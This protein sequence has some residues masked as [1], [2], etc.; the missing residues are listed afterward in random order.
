MTEGLLLAF[1]RGVQ[2]VESAAQDRDTQAF[3]FYLLSFEQVCNAAAEGCSATQRFGPYIESGWVRLELRDAE[4][5]KNSPDDCRQCHQRGLDRPALLMREL[6]GPW[7][8]FFSR[9]DEPAFPYPEP[10]GG[11]L[12]QDFLAAHGDESYAGLPSAVLRDTQPF[13]LRKFADVEQPLLFDA[14]AIVNERWAREGSSYPSEPRRS[15]T[16]DAAF[17]AFK[18]GEQLA[19][20]YFAPRATDP[21]KAQRLTAAYQRF[22]REGAELPDLS[23]VFPD[24]AQTRAEIGLQVEPGAPQRRRWCRPAAVATTMCSIRRSLAR[25]S[26]SRWAVWIGPSWISPSCA[27]ARLPLKAACR[28]GTHDSST[29]SRAMR[30]SSICSAPSGPWKTTPSWSWLR[31]AGCLLHI[32]RGGA[33]SLR[34]TPAHA[35]VIGCESVT[36]APAYLASPA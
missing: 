3:N 13:S 32:R 35:V 10:T 25:A 15:A 16:W 5:L 14:L 23:D 1:T 4:Q 30:S 34:T 24:A 9:E 27:C 18:R 29:R 11:N 22:A 28:L 19:L 33:R 6:N 12:M 31:S 20:P 17:N 2:Q 7:T 36:W 26:M 8:H 21:A